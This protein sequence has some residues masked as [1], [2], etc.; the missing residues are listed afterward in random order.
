MVTLLDGAGGTILWAMAD[1]A[2][3]ERVPVWRYNIE[4]RD[5]VLKM[6]QQ[7][8]AA[9]SRM[10][11]T[12]TFS[13]NSPAVKRSSPYSVSQV[14]KAGVQIAKE[15]CGDS[16]A[17][18]LCS[19]G[20]LSQLMEPFGDLEESEADEI[21]D[22]MISTA[23]ETGVDGVMVETF[24]ELDSACV[25]AKA[26]KRHQLPVFV[27]MSFEKS[28]R[29]LM[30]ASVQDVCAAM[31][32]IH[33]SGVGMNCSLGPELSFP[34]IEEFSRTTKLP[35]VY[36]PNAGLPVTGPDGKIQIPYSAAQFAREVAPAL[37]FVRYIGGCCNSDPDYI[38]EIGKL[39]ETPC[40]GSK[41][42]L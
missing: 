19:V 9:G 39:L 12:N 10:I 2:G 24:M 5:M 30:G 29:T 21:F 32:E 13:A 3:I 1:A 23:A 17:R 34:I 14:V 37:P 28:G 6:H 33:V 41:Q 15:A 31:E 35:L 40:S 4:H 22:E 26:A 20:P 16:G 42:E 18:V 25:A 11:L 7:Y 38:R 36:K 8:I 27:T